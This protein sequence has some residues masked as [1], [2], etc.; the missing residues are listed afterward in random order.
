MNWTN[1]PSRADSFHLIECLHAP[2]LFVQEHMFC[3]NQ[4]VVI[5][6]GGGGVL[7]SCQPRPMMASGQRVCL[8][9]PCRLTTHCLLLP[10]VSHIH[11]GRLSVTT[12]SL[13]HRHLPSIW[14]LNKSPTKR[15][16]SILDKSEK[17]YKFSSERSTQY[18]GSAAKVP[19]VE[20]HVIRARQQEN[21]NYTLSANLS[22]PPQIPGQTPFHTINSRANLH[23]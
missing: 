3:F 2:C 23:L 6:G 5:A 15:G 12:T 20:S 9:S 22:K 13:S 7:G 14:R 1:Q 11:N 4:P 18:Y 17:V 8:T 16:N 21:L 19:V 10:W